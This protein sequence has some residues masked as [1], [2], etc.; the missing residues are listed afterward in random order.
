[1]YS[2]RA[3][4]LVQEYLSKFPRVFELLASD[5]K[6]YTISHFEENNN[7]NGLEY[8]TEIRDWLATLQHF[9]ETKK[10]V[11]SLQLSDVAIN[12][13][14]NAVDAAV[15]LI[16]ASIFGRIINFSLNFS[17]HEQYKTEPKTLKLKWKWQNTYIPDLSSVF[18]LPCPDAVY[19]LLDRVVVVRSGYPVSDVHDVYSLFKSA[20]N[21]KARLKISHMFFQFPIGA[22]GTVIRLEPNMNHTRGNNIT[23]EELYSM[24]ILMDTPFQ[25]QSKSIQFKNHQVFRT[26]STTMLLNI[27]HGRTETVNVLREIDNNTRISARD[28]QGTL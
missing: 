25:I 4:D 11:G 6:L 10:P 3:I 15:S 20:L 9:K 5:D 16:V 22:K 8:L 21:G 1:M 17:P 18:A 14:Q 19:K 7:R 12:D 24:D 26:R 27:S 13:V 2:Q 23:D 28:S